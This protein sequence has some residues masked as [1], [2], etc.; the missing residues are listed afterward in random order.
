MR[1]L[2]K[3]DLHCGSKFPYKL[4]YFPKNIK[5][6]IRNFFKRGVY[7]YDDMDWIEYYYEFCNRNIAIFEDWKKNGVSLFNN[8]ETEELKYF[9]KEEQEEFFNNLIKLLKIMKDED[10]SFEIREEACNKY[11]NIIN[12]YFFTMWD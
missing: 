2:I 1:N 10:K 4:K 8:L 7:G 3:R 9:S 11:F 5:I 6:A 12:T